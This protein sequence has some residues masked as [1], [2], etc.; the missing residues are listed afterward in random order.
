MGRHLSSNLIHYIILLLSRASETGSPTNRSGIDKARGQG[1]FGPSK[2]G[3]G[4]N[5]IPDSPFLLRHGEPGT[6]HYIIL[7]IQ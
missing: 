2:G 3:K 6:S 5:P 1:S 4:T 7:K